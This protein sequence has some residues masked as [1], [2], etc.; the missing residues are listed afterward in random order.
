MLPP[1]RRWT[2]FPKLWLLPGQARPG[3]PRKARFRPQLELLEDR[4]APATITVLSTSDATGP[5]TPVGPDRYTAPSLRAAVDAANNEG[6]LPGADTILFNLPAGQQTIYALLNDT[7]NPNVY[8][9]TAFVITSNIS[10]QGDA[11]R[12]GVMIDG[13]GSHRLFG[14]QA[15]ATLNLEYL[16]VQGGQARG[17]DGGAGTDIGGGGGAGLGG[18]IFNEGVLNI[19]NSTLNNNTAQGGDGG[20]GSHEEDTAGSGGGMGGDG[21]TSGPGGG[22]N[23]GTFPGGNGGFG[24]GGGAGGNIDSATNGGNGGFGGGGGGVSLGTKTGGNGGFGGGGSFNSPGGFGGGNGNGGSGGGAGMGGAIFNNAGTVTLTN[25]T[26][27]S[28]T[29]EGG[30]GASGGGNGQGL[31]GGIFNRDGTLNM[32]NATI[33]HNNATQGGAVYNR[34][35]AGT[36]TVNS[37]NTILADSA[38]DAWNDFDGSGSQ[39][40][41]AGNTNNLVRSNNGFVG[42]G[43]IVGVDPML[44]ALV[45]N[46]GPT[47]THMPLAGSPVINAGNNAAAAGLT[48]D[49][50]GYR[51]RQVGIRVDIGAVEVGAAAP[52]R[53]VT[54]QV[55]LLFPLFFTPLGLGRYQGVFTI[56]NMSRTTI[57]GPIRLSFPILPPGVSVSSATTLTSL[58]PGQAGQIRLVFNNPLRVYLGL[59]LTP[60]FRPLVLAG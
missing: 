25:S 21:Q 37:S 31:G 33:V 15:G 39:S 45:N 38:G 35:D 36:G 11:N 3:V 46:G 24:G 13:N 4:L 20:E 54:S 57:T 16:M 30:L 34:G 27:S 23:G 43:T 53:N 44:N 14:V 8:G 29:A 12:P 51:P 56:V 10:I 32:L 22:P 17:G 55:R 58:R 41:G 59:L 7:T 9:P 6:A 18:A 52:T 40:F 1:R 42:A 47:Q 48:V 49:Q 28:N 26:I 50:R 19:L 2:W 60:L 5:I